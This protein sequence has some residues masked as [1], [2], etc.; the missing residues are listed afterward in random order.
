MPLNFL[1]NAYFTAKVGIGT[2]SPGAKLQVGS[3]GTAGA[4]TPPATDGIL[5]DFHNDG[6]PYTR[7][8]AI[9]SQAGDASE[10]VLDFWTKASSG[11]SSK[12]VTINGIGY[13]GI[14][15]TSPDNTLDVVASDVNI[16]PNAESSAVFRRNGNNYL[17]ILSNASN[18]GGILFGNAVDDND[19]SISYK[20]NTQSMQFATADAER[21][22][23]TSTGNV[24]IGTTSPDSFNSE[25][26]NLVVNG[27]GNVGISI[28]TTTTTGN[29]SVVFADGTGGTAGYRGRLKYG[30][31]TDYMAFFTAAAEKMRITSAGNVG[32]GTTSPAAKLSLYNAT[33]DVSINVNTGTGGSYPKK[34]GISFGAT[35]TSL[36]GDTEFTGGAG[37][38]A[39][40]TA[41][42]N[43]I[44]DLAFWTT[45]GGSPTEKMRITSAGNVGIGTTSP[46]HLLTLETASSPGLKIKDT[47]QGATL[48]AFSQDSNSHIGTY[49]AHPL[50]FDTNSTERMR[51]DQNGNVGIGTTNPATWK[52]SVD[53]S[54]IYAAS[55]DTSNNVG[56]VIN[57]NNTTASQIIGFSN[58]NS[59]YNELHL[60]TNSTST[61]GLYIDASGNVGIGTTAPGEKLEVVGNI[62]TNVGNGL[63]FMLTGSSASGL[64]RNAGTGLALRTNSIDK[65]I[66]D[67]TGSVTFSAYTGT[68]EQGT[69]TY[70]LGTDA[71]GNVVKTLS[72]PGGDPGPYLPLAGGTMTGALTINLSSEGTYFTGGSSAIRQLSITSGTN[73]SANALHT[74]NIASSN[75]K[76]EFDVNGTTEFSLDSSSAV[77][78]GNVGIGTTSPVTKLHLYDNTATVG[79]SIQADNASNS[80]INLGDEDDINIGRIQYSHST[81]SM[82]LRTNNAERMRIDSS[83]NVMIGNTGAG[84]KLDVRADTGYVF[85]TE[86][87]SGNTFR[88]EASSGNIYT[89]GDLYIP[90]KIIHVGDEDTWMQ[91]ETNVISL[92]TGGTDR[93]TLTN[94]AATFAGD[95][96]L[97]GGSLSISGDGSNAV[98][99]TETGAGKM[100]V[101]AADD[102]ILDAG[103]DIVLDAGGD[104]LR[105][106]VSGTEYAKFNNSSS[107]L[108]IFSSIQDK[109]I[110]F[111]GNDNGTEIT[112]LTLNMADGG[113]ADFLGTVTSPTFLGDLNGTINTATTGVTQ[114]NA[115]DNT[116]IATTA[117][118]NNKIALIPAGLVFQGTWNAATNTPTLTSGSGTTGHFYIVSTDGSTNLDG[119]T[120]WK[121]GDWAVFIEQGASDQWEKIDNSSVLDGFGTGQ[122]LPLWSGSGTSNTLDNSILTQASQSIITQTAGTGE[123][124]QYYLNSIAD[125]DSAISFQQATVQKAKIGY[126][127]SEGALAFVHGG[128]AFSAAGMVLDSTGVGIGTTSPTFKLHV[129]ST[130]ASDNVAYIHHNNAAQ[131]SGD[132][133]KVRSDAGD[134]AGSAL[135]NVANNTGS[136]LYVR[137]DRNVGVGTTSPN[138]SLHVIG[139]VAIDNST[140]PSGGLLVS[141]DGTSNKVYSRTGNATSSAHPLDFI[142]GSSTSMRIAANGNV[143]IGTTSPGTKLD[144]NGGIQAGGKVTYTRSAG[145]LNTTGYAVAG[146]TTSS[147]GQSAGFTFT[148]FGH[149]GG[150]QKIVYSC[151]NGGGTWVTKKVINEGTNQL[152]VVASANGTTITFTFK[153]ISGTMS[154]TPRVTVEA[155]GTAINSTYA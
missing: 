74:F 127:H 87:A 128:G 116:T 39:I 56:V 149:T 120:D 17:T 12:K 10:S 147:N 26:R 132:V 15:T 68:N 99:F 54:N 79:L 94:S 66:I 100:T 124:A 5:F 139:Q 62:R 105:L 143:G 98:T 31:A 104:D 111:I 50:V 107:N 89:T 135:L 53:S 27:S 102:I 71:S 91:F 23:I 121:V 47:T 136:A 151:Y 6:P 126:D 8:A 80:D 1:N 77:F 49:S 18:E 95:V 44:T 25:A 93:L 3:R 101:S 21:M 55:F 60:R 133:L 30:H 85:R 122:T 109:S 96:S 9:I 20:H 28:A 138:R 46:T 82:Q 97:T 140:S 90:N 16:T 70:L 48:L 42:S 141:P 36:G 108:N 145:S 69:P 2:E 155:V 134:N 63:G 34:T 142:S 119:I 86:N 110:K 73:I 123:V 83:G 130:D 32:I 81:D 117:Y 35:S 125:R 51:I 43:N 92:R 33:E 115:I 76:Y 19:G 129:N 52:L 59:T 148:C 137:G 144:V 57:G 75:G 154:Y 146:L 152:D 150:Y 106:K 40:N 65:L 45:T 113:D 24:G 41:A 37:I 112:A 84:A 11:T 72:T 7:H 88:I 114:V 22:R 29:S 153:S 64:V 13:V 78:T 67:S 58:S 103:S 4:L 61:D 118:V 131:S 14:G 38:Q